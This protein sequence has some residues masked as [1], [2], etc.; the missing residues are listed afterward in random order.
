MTLGGYLYE[1]I[2]SL[3]LNVLRSALTAIGVIVGTAGV[4]V[5]GSA[6]SGANKTIEQQIVKWGTNTLFVSTVSAENSTQRGPAVVLTDEDAAAISEQAPGIRSMSREIMG[7]VILVLG[8]KRMKSWFRGV[9]ASFADVADFETSEGRFFS[10]DEVVSGSRVA[11]IGAAVAAKLFGDDSPLG[12]TLRMGGLA[13][14]VIGVRTRLGSVFGR[15]QD[16][17]VY[18]P[19]TMARSRLPQE[20]RTSA[21]QISFIHLKAQSGA[22]RGAASESVLALLRERKHVR[23]GAKNM[24]DVFDATQAIRLSHE[25]HATLS[26]LLAATAA[27]S[28][29]AGGAGIMNIMLVSVTERTREIGLRRAIGARRRDILAQFLIEA[30]LLCVAAGAAGV[31]LGVAGA[32][33]VASMSGWPVIIPPTTIALALMAAAG[34]GI[35]FGYLPAHRAAALNPIDALRCE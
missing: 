14:R 25:T 15:D 12:R 1:A 30:V 17:F 33:I 32:Y 21:N 27:V 6:G 13:V 8:N 5:L 3:R 16:N 31:A 22:D 20:S 34:T 9:D 29:V 35:V 4:I 11:V 18:V 28:L 7:N 2:T 24:F 23:E 19:V 26:Y 10:A